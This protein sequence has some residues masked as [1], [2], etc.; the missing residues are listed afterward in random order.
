MYQ[1]TSLSGSLPNV[2][3]TS[4]DRPGPAR[5][6]STYG[7]SDHGAPLSHWTH[8]TPFP[9]PEVWYHPS[10]RLV[11]GHSRGTG[12]PERAPGLASTISSCSP[13]NRG[14]DDLDEGGEDEDEDEDELPSVTEIFRSQPARSQPELIDLTLDLSDEVST[15]KSDRRDL[16]LIATGHRS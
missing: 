13:E 2:P 3:N 10:T 15:S 4:P 16:E 7:H 11:M 12:E 1:P 6:V 8:R 9:G 5:S 14:A